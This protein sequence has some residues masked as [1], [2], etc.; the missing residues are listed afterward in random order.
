MPQATLV[1]K[2]PSVSEQP[3]WDFPQV[4][5][6]ELDNGFTILSA[7]VPGQLIGVAQFV[8]DAGAGNEI[9]GQ[10]GLANLAAQ[11]LLEGTTRH[12]GASF[13]NAVE[14]LGAQI[15][16][17]A[18]WDTFR[19]NLTAPIHR[20]EAAMEL[21]AEAALQ[22]EFPTKDVER[23]K[24]E[25]LGSILQEYSTPSA[26]AEIAFDKLAYTPDS[27]YYRPQG[28]AYWTVAQHG[29]RAIKKYYDTMAT[30]GKAA[31]IVVGDLEEV[32]LVKIGEKLFGG[33]KGKDQPR[34]SITVKGAPKK[35]SVLV[36]D[37]EDAEQSHI[38]I[39]HYGVSRLA[40]N[41]VPLVAVA[42]ALG[43]VFGSRLNMRLREEKGYTY[44][45]GARFDFRREA[46][47]FGISTA[48]DTDVTVDAVAQIIDVLEDLVENGMTE[49]ELADVKSFLVGS[50]C[51]QYETPQAIANALSALVTY[52]LPD[53]Y[54]QSYR[55]V[56][57][58][59]TLEDTAE[60]A[61][62]IEPDG[63][64]IV[65]VGDAVKLQDPLIDADFGPVAIIE[66]PEA[67]EPPTQ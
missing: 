23:L 64:A 67:G 36:V 52:G 48:V 41:Y 66:D 32:P 53:D 51:L 6:T 18:G 31:L 47:P 35:N 39:G 63:L 20:M 10:Y 14:I 58:N 4:N 21:L 3:R 27:A 7:H 45:I 55:E 28:G 61:T 54:Y 11:S 50:F 40:S 42:T 46:G 60:A 43:G 65:I 19:V 38:L 59:V 5:R 62:Y 34:P 9:E 15:G 17:G 1:A 8:L 22:P 13:I 33:W 44:G 57:E 29:K 25:R 37:R 56:I 49:Q 26:R 12:K 2:R 30:P 24:E 16:A